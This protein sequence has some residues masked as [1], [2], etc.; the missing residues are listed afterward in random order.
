M[1]SVFD[2]DGVTWVYT[3]IKIIE[4][5]RF[6]HLLYVCYISVLKIL[7]NEG[8]NSTIIHLPGSSY[9]PVLPGR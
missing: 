5:L 8:L 1:F 9:F 4:T 7:N 2:L 6:V 3:Y